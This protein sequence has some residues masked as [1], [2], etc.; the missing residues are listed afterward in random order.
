MTLNTE[1]FFHG[2][3]HDIE[4][5][6]VLPGNQVG[7]ANYDYDPDYGLAPGGHRAGDYVHGGPELTA[8][9]YAGFGGRRRVYELDPQV[10]GQPDPNLKNV[11]STIW[12]GPV[13]I[14][15]QIDIP[16]PAL[17]GD[18]GKAAVTHVQGTLPPV[19]WNHYKTTTGGDANYEPIRPAAVHEA[20]ANQEARDQLKSD[21]EAKRR[22]RQI[23]G[24]GKLL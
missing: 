24:Q 15:R 7:K 20:N 23:P 9:S 5:G 10:P 1:Q 3:T 19:N 14:K 12:P 13:R 2:S 8:W 11:P 22:L 16:P 18:S 4:G 21:R 17:W 6:H